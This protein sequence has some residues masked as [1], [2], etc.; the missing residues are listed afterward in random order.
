[1]T[2]IAS[3]PGRSSGS[4]AAIER[5][6]RIAWPSAGHLLG[7][8]VPAGQPV[9]DPQRGQGQRDQGRDPVARPQ[10][11]R[12]VRADLVDDA[13]EHAAG[14]GD[15]VLHLAARRDDLQH[16]R[17]GRRAVAVVLGRRAAGT[18]RRRG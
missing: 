15:R 9:G 4:R 11:Q 8:A 6:N 3:S 7:A 17:R 10:P 2:A 1:M 12:R 14:A 16:L 13:D 5:P 18:T